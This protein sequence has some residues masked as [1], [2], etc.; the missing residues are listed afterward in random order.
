[1][2]FPPSGPGIGIWHDRE[3]YAACN[4]LTKNGWAWEYLRR[5]QD[6]QEDFHRIFI[7]ANE[8]SDGPEQHLQ[9]PGHLPMHW[10]AFFR[11]IT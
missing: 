5:N 6:F 11:D 8:T 4:T 3:N 1:M 2:C 7:L 10:G 9:L